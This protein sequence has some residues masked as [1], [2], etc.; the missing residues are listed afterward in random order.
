M[1]ALQR[2]VSCELSAGR[3]LI[4]RGLAFGVNSPGLVPII[5]PRACWK[6]RRSSSCLRQTGRNQQRLTF[7]S[8]LTSAEG[9]GGRIQE[10]T[11]PRETAPHLQI[12]HHIHACARSVLTTHTPLQTHSEPPETDCRCQ[13]H[14][15][16]PAGLSLGLVPLRRLLTCNPERFVP[17]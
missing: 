8:A 4:L 10:V 5:C 2:G 12:K 13:A 15:G 6:P 11:V 17:V 1:F 3:S 7:P 16:V 9:G 14:L